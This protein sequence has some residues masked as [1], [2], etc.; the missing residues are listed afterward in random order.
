MRQKPDVVHREK[1]PLETAGRVTG[2]SS[3]STRVASTSDGVLFDE[4]PALSLRGTTGEPEKHQ[5]RHENVEVAGQEDPFAFAA[6]ARKAISPSSTTLS[7]QVDVSERHETNSRPGTDDSEGGIGTAASL[8][9]RLLKI[10][11][12]TKPPA[13]TVVTSRGHT[14]APSSLSVESSAL[15]DFDG[16]IS[17]FQE[18]TRRKP[19]C[20]EDDIDPVTETLKRFH[21]AL[22]KQP[23]PFSDS[24]DL[25]R[26]IGSHLSKVIQSITR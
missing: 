3:T 24:E 17:L 20:S 25:R 15:P 16:C 23:E 7:S 22:S 2:T 9:A 4:L 14:R 18:I 21:A 10:R 8:R 13:E 12:K 11:E 26:E 19:P 6:A 5:G 1:L